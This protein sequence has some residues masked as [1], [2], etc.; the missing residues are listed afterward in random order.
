MTM[1]NLIGLLDRRMRRGHGIVH[2]KEAAGSPFAEVPAPKRLY[3]PLLQHQGNPAVPVVKR[4]DQ[5]KVGT[6][7]ARADGVV[8]APVH[9]SVSGKVRAIEPVLHPWG[10]WSD[11]VVIDNDGKDEMED[12]PEPVHDPTQLDPD[13]IRQ[14]IRDAGIVGMGGAMFPAAVKLSVLEPI[15]T[16]IINGCECEPELTCD[17]RTMLERTDAMLYGMKALKHVLKPKRVVLAIESNKPDAIRLY[18]E[19]AKVRGAFE[20]AVMPSRYPYGAE[21][22]L[23][24]AVTGK[25]IPAGKY[26][27]SIGVV[28]QNVATVTAIHDALRF[29]MPL[30]KRPLTV[31]GGAV[32]ESRNLIVRIGTPVAHVLDWVGLTDVPRELVLG[33]PMMGITIPG[34]EAPVIKGT[35]GIL[36][37]TYE[38]LHHFQESACVRCGRCIDTCPADLMPTQLARLSARGRFDEAEALGAI[39]CM[40][41]GLCSYRC[42]ADLPLTQLIRMGK[43]EILKKMRREEE[44][45]NRQNGS[46]DDEATDKDA[47]EDGAAA[48]VGGNV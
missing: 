12:L 46:A 6:L 42:P 23:V 30:I 16:L 41:C 37:R 9:S 14:R 7:L 25:H 26:P 5:V 13:E 21:R 33:G 11:T 36:A 47:V 18:Q 45:A 17:H 29:G 44:E 4:G 3:I 40:E 43:R 22:V 32:A 39:E 27:D 35:S 28:V 15:D 24:P 48:S 38:E 1:F 20:V 2:E 8:S 34:P 10:T 31:A 19:L